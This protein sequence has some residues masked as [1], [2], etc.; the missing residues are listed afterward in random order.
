MY[1][2]VIARSSLSV[3]LSAS[4]QIEMIKMPANLKRTDIVIVNIKGP[5]NC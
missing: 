2:P 3:I 5:M 1:C 4:F